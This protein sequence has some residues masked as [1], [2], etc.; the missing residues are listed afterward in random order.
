MRV[1]DPGHAYL[2]ACLDRDGEEEL[3]FVKR[4]GDK[5]P[6]NDSSYGGTTTQEVIRA[7]IDRTKY[8]NAQEPSHTNDTV[9]G[10]LRAALWE[11]EMRAADRRG[12]WV[13]TRLKG[14]IEDE[15]TCEQC[16]HI[17]SAHNGPCR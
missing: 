4:Q 17:P 2:L 16:G 6:G 5:Y 15:P 11:L 9:L 10:Y 8:V 12:T 14:A 7:L 3:F 1:I 13:S